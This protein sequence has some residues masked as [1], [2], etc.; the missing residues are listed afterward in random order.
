M[1][2]AYRNKRLEQVL[3]GVKTVASLIV[4]ASFALLFGFYSPPYPT[5]S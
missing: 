3:I 5:L 4:V 1:R 2:I